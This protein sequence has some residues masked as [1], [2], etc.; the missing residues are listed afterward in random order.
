MG[1]KNTLKYDKL[2]FFSF[3]TFFSIFVKYTEKSYKYKIDRY[4]AW[5][6]RNAQ[7]F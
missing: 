4:S 6:Y 7:M 2:K 3:V 5:R 1:M